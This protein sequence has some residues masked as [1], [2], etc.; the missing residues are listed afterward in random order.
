[1]LYDSKMAHYFP[2]E[3]GRQ[4][5]LPPASGLKGVY[6]SLFGIPDVRGQVTALYLSDALARIPFQSV[7]DVGCGNGM[8]TCLM[9]KKYPQR[10][11]LGIDLDKGGVDFAS[12]LSEQNALSRVRFRA[13][14]IEDQEVS[15]A[16]DLITCFAVFQFIR[17][18]PAL[19]QKFNML[20]ADNGHLLLQLPCAETKNYLGK[21]ALAQKRMPDFREARGGFTQEEIAELLHKE[22]FELVECRAIIKGPSI[23]VKELFYFWLTKHPKI[24]FALSPL[25]N[26][27]TVYDDKYWGKGNGLFVI[28][29]KTKNS[30]PQGREH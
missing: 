25:F 11:F 15:G 24:V 20:L 9:G 13:C 17:D 14:N 2:G 3:L 7:L 10:E 26:W 21:T 19:L 16:Y 12:R 4:F 23:W 8:L 30:T 28:A 27:V 18:I 6:L 5:V 29:K 1:M 22:G